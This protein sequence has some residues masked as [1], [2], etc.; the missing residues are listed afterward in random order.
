MEGTDALCHSMLHSRESRAQFILYSALQLNTV[1]VE[2]S[3]TDFK[4]RKT[5]IQT[6]AHTG[7]QCVCYICMGCSIMPYEGRG[8]AG[9][10]FLSS[11]LT[12][13]FLEWISITSMPTL[14]NR[15]AI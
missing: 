2:W 7:R 4:Q 15:A 12:C 5:H 14:L 6:H 13:D 8:R 10:G 9:Q 3:S 1:Y 11:P